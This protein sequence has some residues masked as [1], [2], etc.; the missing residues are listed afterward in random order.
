MVETPSTLRR[1]GSAKAT[2]CYAERFLP[3]LWFT[4]LHKQAS[5]DTPICRKILA[6]LYQKKKSTIKITLE[7]SGQTKMVRF[8]ISKSLTSKHLIMR[9]M[10]IHS[11]EP[12]AGNLHGGFCG[13]RKRVICAST[14]HP[15]LYLSFFKSDL[16]LFQWVWASGLAQAASQGEN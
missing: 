8:T 14:R 11:E 9:E 6:V 2:C 4:S 1:V 16:Y 15:I 10:A 7:S 12:V 13:G 3:I 5:I